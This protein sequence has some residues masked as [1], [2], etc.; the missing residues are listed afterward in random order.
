MSMPA[1]TS[2][3]GRVRLE[4]ALHPALLGAFLIFLFS[5]SSSGAFFYFSPFWCRFVGMLDA[6]APM[7]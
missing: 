3:V 6:T 7:A 1:A 5:W 2:M 4:R